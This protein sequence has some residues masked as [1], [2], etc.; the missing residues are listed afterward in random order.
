MQSRLYYS[1]QRVLLLFLFGSFLVPLSYERGVI[2]I[3]PFDFVLLPLMSLWGLKA[4][5]NRTFHLTRS[6]LAL[7]GLAVWILFSS[8]L[9]LRPELS[10]VGGLLWFRGAV[11]FSLCRSL[12]GSAYDY[13]DIVI[14]ASGVLFLEA[15]LATIQGVAQVDVGTLNQYFGQK[16][17]LRSYRTLA[18]HRLLRAQGTF[19][20]PNTLASWIAILLPIVGASIPFAESRTEYRSKVIIVG[21]SI[22]GLL[23]S[24]SRGIIAITAGSLFLLGIV[25]YT[26]QIRQFSPRIATFLASSWILLM[27]IAPTSILF[28]LNSKRS[29]LADLG[30]ELY[31]TAPI[32][33]IGYNNYVPAAT[34]ILEAD[35]FLQATTTSVHNVP[36]LFL[37]ETGFVGFSLFL[38]FIYLI[39]VGTIKQAINSRWEDP[40]LIGYVVALSISLGIMQLYLTPTSFQFL[41]LLLALY[42]AAMGATLSR[43][44]SPELHF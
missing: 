37:V 17:P 9:V 7:L 34:K 2:Q 31:F 36:I 19:G 16:E 6:D 25:L 15:N 26:Q 8:I 40:E 33:G 12:Y 14:V 35:I 39:S 18:G 10:V 23:F 13:N 1:V 29:E 4:H 44:N 24:L 27:T 21:L 3:Y 20:N 41:P 22:V 11:I 5:E 43:F 38:I 30:I 32:T 42:G 28:I